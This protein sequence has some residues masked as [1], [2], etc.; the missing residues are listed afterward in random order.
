MMSASFLLVTSFWLPCGRFMTPYVCFPRRRLVSCTRSPCRHLARSTFFL[1]TKYSININ[2]TMLLLNRCRCPPCVGLFL[3]PVFQTVVAVIYNPFTNEL[4]QS[5][6]GGGSYLNGK[7]LE[8]SETT[9]VDQAIVVRM[10]VQMRWNCCL[11]MDPLRCAALK[12]HT[13]CSGASFPL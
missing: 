2:S 6:K 3:V 9:A 1:A 7:R 13:G 4:Y 11:F 12:N 8:V 5:V 10:K